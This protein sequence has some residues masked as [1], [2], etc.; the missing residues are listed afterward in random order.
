MLSLRTIKN[1]QFFLKGYREY[2]DLYPV[3]CTIDTRTPGRKV[4]YMM[5]RLYPEYE[6]PQCILKCFLIYLAV[7][8][9]SCGMWNSLVARKWE[10]MHPGTED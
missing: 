4:N 1:L 8:G 10:Q 7:L 3:S 6:L 5:T 2:S 9:L